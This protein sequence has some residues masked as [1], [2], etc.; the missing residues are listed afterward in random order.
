[1]NN[2]HMIIEN[3]VDSRRGPENGGRLR[4]RIR[5]GLVGPLVLLVP[6]MAAA[7][8]GCSSTASE[9]TSSMS[10]AVTAPVLGA[11]RSYAVLAG[12]TVTNTGSTVVTGDLGVS[13]GTAVTGFPPG[14]VKGGAI[15]SADANALQAQTDTTTAYNALAGQS[16]DRTL[17]GT[18]LGGLTLTTGTYCFSSSAQLTGTLT[19]DAQG[20]PSAVFVFQMGSTLTTASNSSVVMINGGNPCNVYWQV[21]SSATLGTGTTFEGNILALASITLTTDVSLTG[22][23]LARTAAVTMDTNVVNGSS[24]S[25]SATNSTDGGSAADAV[26]PTADAVSPVVDAVSPVVDA[27]SPAVDAIS[28]AVDACPGV[29]APPPPPPPPPPEIIDSGVAPGTDAGEGKTY[30]GEKCVDLQ[31]D[32]NHCGSC[33]TNCSG[34]E[35][36]VEGTCVNPQTDCNHCGPDDQACGQDES[37]IKGEC[38]ANSKPG[39]GWWPM[40]NLSNYHYNHNQSWGS[41]HN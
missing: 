17:T 40:W 30:C 2:S 24:C 26:S 18:D 25:G 35:L 31:T 28:P 23:A 39:S 16:C 15:H 14:Q 7:S 1:M 32:S 12:S 13:P 11:A 29:A 6:S 27:I 4:S 22:R 41:P 38:S 37:C 9:G 3:A 10:Q 21:G 33:N 5:R 20:D 19:L 8:M 34:S 36:C